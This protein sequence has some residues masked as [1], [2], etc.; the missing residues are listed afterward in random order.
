VMASR[1]ASCDVTVALVML[2]P[3]FS[4]SELLFHVRNKGF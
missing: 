4:N 1:M 2:I 3:L